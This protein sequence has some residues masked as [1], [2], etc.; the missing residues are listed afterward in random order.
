MLLHHPFEYWGRVRAE[1]V[2]AKDDTSVVTYGEARAQALRIGRALVAHGVT[3]GDRVAVLA[4]NCVEL[5]IAYYGVSFSGATF[6]PVNSRFAPAERKH[7]LTDSGA[8]VLFVSADLFDPAYLPDPSPEVVVCRGLAPAGYPTLEEWLEA[9]GQNAA[10]PDISEDDDAFQ[11]YTSGTTGRPKAAVLTHTNHFGIVHRWQM[12]SL[13]LQPGDTM[14]LAMPANLGAGLYVVLNAVYSGACVHLAPRFDPA[15]TVRVLDETTDGGVAT[16][17]APTMIQACLAADGAKDR[18]YA[19]LRWILYGAAPISAPLLREALDTF[20]CDFIQGFGQTEVSVVTFLLASDH[21]DALAGR[22]H[23]LDSVGRL[24]PGVDLR[25]VDAFDEEVP[26][27]EPGEIC[28]RSDFVMRCYWGAPELTAQTERGGWHHTGDVGYLDDEGFLYVVDR[29]DDMVITGGFNVYPREVELVI[30][31]F[32]EVAQVAVFG[33]ASEKWGQE[34]TAVL[35]LVPQATLTEE[36]VIARCKKELAG[37]K[38]PKLVAF[39]DAFEVNANG[40]VRK[41]LLRAMFSPVT[42]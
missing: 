19:N 33:I 13:R 42:K 32:P 22:E 21:R 40:K 2:F 20:E 27:G 10:L 12:A 38:V 26:P 7:V 31:R 5:L 3:R 39:I 16:A 41:D 14:Y 29:I 11:V 30:E 4:G 36:E 1:E 23:L 37:Y 6:V 9:R 34:V 15:E 35:R 18:G 8:K 25:F 17:M 24:N 28:V